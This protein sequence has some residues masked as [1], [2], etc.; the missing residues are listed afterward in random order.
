MAQQQPS[1]PWFRLPSIARPVIDPTPAPV[2]ALAPPTV[3]PSAPVARPAFRQ[4]N[5]TQDPTSTVVAPPTSVTPKSPP[6]QG[7][8]AT[9]VPTSPIIR[10]NATS[11]SLPTSPVAPTTAPAAPVVTTSAVPSSP[12]PRVSAPTSSLPTSPATRT[13]TQAAPSSPMPRVSAPTS[14][15]SPS[16]TAPKT[17]LS[18][19]VANS[20]MPKPV[21]TTFSAPTASPKTMPPVNPMTS[22]PIRMAVTTNTAA[23]TATGVARPSPP[24]ATVKQATFQTTPPD[25]PKPKPTA[26]PPSP[27]ILPP[28]KMK[29]DPEI[30]QEV[31]QKRVLV[32]KTSSTDH[33]KPKTRT[34]GSPPEKDSGDTHKSGI[35]HSG[36]KETPKDHGQSK[37]KNHHKK[38]N[39]ESEKGG[40]RVI[41]IAGENKGAY[42][43]VIRSPSKKTHVFEGISHNLHKNSSSSSSSSSSSEEEEDRQRKK[44]EKGQNGKKMSSGFMS[45]FMN[46]NVQGVNN[47]IVYNSSC[48]HHDPGVHLA[49]SRKPATGGGKDHRNNGN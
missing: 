49:L 35:G 2:Q 33:N 17:A 5:Q 20:P 45:T 22:S 10:P 31:E 42:M 29:S 27:L 25:S 11:S 44:M 32:Q 12:R 23:P 40:M 36:K 19:S 14:S 39:S 13:T 8:G 24:T 37:D 48:S 3:A 18:S 16:S 34:N 30:P 43:E 4:A 47:S 15:L 41:T 46:S 38:M 21:S 26:P 9:S 7:G 1:R 6:K 28:A